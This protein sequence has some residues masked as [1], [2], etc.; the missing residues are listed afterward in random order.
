VAFVDALE[1]RFGERVA[2]K[3]EEHPLRRWADALNLSDQQREQIRTAMREHTHGEH[4]HGAKDGGFGKWQHSGPHLGAKVLAAFK[5][6]RFVLDEVAPAQDPAKQ[7]HRAEA[8]VV[9]LAEAALPVLTAD[10]RAAAAKLIR[11][12][13]DEMF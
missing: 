9:N 2:E 5:E 1:A 10:Q 13:A 8:R 12:K 6:D 7:A 11:E 4:P 3:A